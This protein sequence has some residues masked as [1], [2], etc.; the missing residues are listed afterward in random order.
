MPWGALTVED[1]RF[2]LVTRMLAKEAS[3]TE[4][5]RSQGI[6]R[7]TAYKWQERFLESGKA[8]LSDQSRARITQPNAVSEAVKQVIIQARRAHSTWGAKKLLPWLQGQRPDLTLPSLSTVGQILADAGLTVPKGKPRR[9]PVAAIDRSSEPTEPNQTWAIDFKGQFRTGDRRLCYPLTVTDRAS[10]FLLLARAMTSTSGDPVKRA[11]EQLFIEHGLPDRIRSDN[12]TPFAGNGLGRLSQLSVW[13]MSLDIMPDLI[14]PGCPYQNGR[15]ERMHRVLKAE[16]TKPPGRDLLEQQALFDAFEKEYNTQRPHEALHFACPQAV[17]RRSDRGYT[18][19][20]KADDDVFA[21]HFERRVVKPTGC[22][23]WK[24]AMVYISQTLAGRLVGL[25][26]TRED[27]YVIQY[28][29]YPVGLLNQRDGEARVED[30]R[31][32]GPVPDQAASNAAAAE[33]PTS[34]LPTDVTGLCPGPR[35]LAHEA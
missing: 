13:W 27:I 32:P 35:D 4:L 34:L 28:R 5:V 20:S 8:G 3:V 14:D 19:A 25:H 33:S 10:R 11:L 2:A 7:K 21:G 9:K 12:G 17:H 6:S 16:T 22:I 24:G 30:L 15:H 31:K 1:S 29:H 23:K 18:P 26:E